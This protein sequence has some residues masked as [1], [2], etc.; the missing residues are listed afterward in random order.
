MRLPIPSWL[1]WPVY[2]FLTGIVFPL[3]ILVVWPV[4]LVRQKRRRTLLPRLGFQKYPDLDD[5][6]PR[7]VWVH[8]LSV[9]ELISALPLIEGLRARLGH[10][11]VVVSVSTLAAHQIAEKRLKGSIDGLFYFPYETAMAYRRCLARIRPG[12]FVLVETDIWPGYL[13][14]FSKSGVRS[15][16]VNG[17]LSERSL[18]SRKRWWCLFGPAFEAF[19]VIYGQSA[20]ETERFASLGI[21]RDRLGRPGNLKFDATAQV[22]NEG[23]GEGLRKV[24]GFGPDDRIILAGSTHRGEEAVLLTAFSRLRVDD[25]DLKLL[26]VPRHPERAEEVVDLS[27]DAGF[28]FARLTDLE[29]RDPDVVVINRI[30]YLSRLYSIAEIAFVGGSL[31][32]KGGQNPIEPAMAA[33]PILFGPDM[34]DFPD[35]APELVEAGGASVVRD[36]DEIYA[37]CREWLDHPDRAIRAGA[38]ALGVIERHRGT[39]GRLIEEISNRLGCETK[40]PS[41]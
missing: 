34:S 11:P 2:L 32:P 39:T 6:R 22:A 40:E 12:L 8:A 1:A 31:V 41:S 23:A 30:G 13:R 16:L 4:L 5:A 20:G 18:R 37:R 36:G 27:L 38:N 17:R 26:V 15:L 3:V 28:K 21:D 33:K 25:P 10:R 35:I 29:N 7:P 9:G 19:E 24:L 14:R